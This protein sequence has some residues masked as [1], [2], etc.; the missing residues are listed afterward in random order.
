MSL[1]LPFPPFLP[2]SFILPFHHPGLFPSPPVNIPLFFPF[3]LI[4]VVPFPS[5]SFHIHAIHR[6]S[7]PVHR[8]PS[9]FFPPL[10]VIA[11]YLHSFFHSLSVIAIHSIPSPS[12]PSHRHSFPRVTEK[13]PRTRTR[14]AKTRPRPGQTHTQDVMAVC[15][16][17]C[18]CVCVKAEHTTGLPQQRPCVCVCVCDFRTRPVYSFQ[19]DKILLFT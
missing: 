17:V 8:C 7:L 15:A 13:L 6:P 12:L 9:H 5:L 16:P 10:P 19:L 14:R 2:F 3:L 11:I 18:V 4:H 1:W